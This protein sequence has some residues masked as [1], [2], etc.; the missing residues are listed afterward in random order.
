MG[1]LHSNA[2]GIQK[3]AKVN[4][5]GWLIIENLELPL[6]LI[7]SI[8]YGVKENESA[9]KESDNHARKQLSWI[10]PQLI[11]KITNARFNFLFELQVRGLEL[12]NI[13]TKLNLAFS[14]FDNDYLF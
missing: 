9:Q 4:K 12:Y 7:V 11:L 2:V 1:A 8:V 6:F 3:P 13:L 10:Y 5:W 14:V